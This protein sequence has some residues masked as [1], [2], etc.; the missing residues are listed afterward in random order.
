MHPGDL[1]KPA[2]A[3]QIAPVTQRKY[4]WCNF[5]LGAVAVCYAFFAVAAAYTQSVIPLLV[6][7]PIL[8]PIAGVC[9]YLKSK[10]KQ[11]RS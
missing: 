1:V 11:R 8:L 5:V 7:S 10:S 3:P 6:V 4:V 2:P 9:L